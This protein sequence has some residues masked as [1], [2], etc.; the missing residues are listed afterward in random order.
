MLHKFHCD[1]SILKQVVNEIRAQFETDTDRLAI[2]TPDLYAETVDFLNNYFIPSEP[3]CISFGVTM[4]KAFRS[5]VIRCLQAS[6]SVCLINTTTGQ[7]IGILTIEIVQKSDPP[8]DP[9]NI[10]D[11]QLREC[12]RFNHQKEGDL[13]IFE[14]FDSDMAVNFFTLVV[15]PKYRQL[16]IGSRVFMAAV[17]MCKGLGIKGIRGEG[18]S[19]FS[20]LIFEKNGF[21]TLFT[22]PY[23]NYKTPSGRTIQETSGEHT[24][25]KLYVLKL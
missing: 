6:L 11:E 20:Q 9:S 22:M 21:E 7:I 13:H 18:T 5:K 2:I 4:S 12:A 16:G 15:N 19:N 10:S 17:A 3:L 24:S 1:I 23:D 25:S 8:F 14:R